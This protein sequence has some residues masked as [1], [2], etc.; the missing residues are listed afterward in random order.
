MAK[1]V[2]N[3][4]INV[5]AIKLAD[6]YLDKILER[7]A[8][9]ALYNFNANNEWEKTDVEG[10]LF[11]YSRTGEPKYNAF[12][13]N[14]LSTTN[15]IEPINEGLD[16]Q[17]QEP[18]LLYKTSGGQ[19]HAIWFYDREECVKIAKAVEKLVTEVTV[20][21][22]KKVMD[23]FAKAGSKTPNQSSGGGGFIGPRAPP[24]GIQ[25]Q[26]GNEVNPL[27]Q[28]LISNPVQ[29]VEQIEKQHT[30]LQKNKLDGDKVRPATLSVTPQGKLENGLSCLRISESPP[31]VYTPLTIPT[32]NFFSQ[33][34]IQSPSKET[35][36][37]NQPVSSSTPVQQALEVSLLERSVTGLS[38]P[39]KPALL[40][41]G[42]FTTPREETRIQPE[43]LTKTQL[44]QA[45]TYLLKN[46]A[47]F[48]KKLHEA[49]VKS[50]SDMMS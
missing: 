12:V 35:T 47:D 5:S 42:M 8:H 4:S 25:R 38:T 33:S 23:F 30:A 29:T 17:L 24:P 18:F 48:I 16:L 6:P 36:M 39:T 26:D 27:L 46:D 20:T 19:I 1:S 41:P 7:A 32:Q 10:A 37:P 22:N 3:N 11:L 44:L 28:R 40:P 43:P 34:H 49:Y 2:E 15:L 21:K 9:V 14:R 45:V 31:K 13:L 50:F